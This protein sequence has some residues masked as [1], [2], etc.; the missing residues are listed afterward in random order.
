MI[1]CFKQ[2]L[3]LAV[4]TS[5]FVAGLFAGQAQAQDAATPSAKDRVA[6]RY[7]ANAKSGSANGSQAGSPAPAGDGIEA[8]IEKIPLPDFVKD[9]QTDPAV[10]QHTTTGAGLPAAEGNPIDMQ[11]SAQRGLDAN[12]QMQSARAILSG[13]EQQRRQAMANFGAVGTV[14]YTFQRTDAQVISQNAV[15]I[16]SNQIINSMT[17]SSL[18]TSTYS[19]SRIGYWKNLYQLQLTATQ[20]LFTGFKL[21]SSYQKAELSREQAE[22]NIKYTELSLIKAVQ[23]AF[24]TLLQARSNVQSNKDSVARLESQYKVA[25]AYYDVGLKPRLDV[26]QA[27]SDLAQAEQNLLKAENDV[28]VQTAQLNSLLNL[29]LNQQTNYVGELTYIPFPMSIEECLDTA[30]KLRPDLYMGV[31]TVQMAERD[32]KIAASTFYPQV[33]AQ[34]TYTK[35]GNQ[36]D[37]GLKDSSGATT[38]DSAAIG[39]GATLQAWDWGSTYFGVQSARENV[40]K[41][42]ADLA[43]LRLDV[44]YQVKTFYLNIQDAAKRISV[45]RTALEASREGYRMAVAR[46]QAQVGTS[47]DVLDAQAR[48]SSAEFNLTQALTDYQSALADIY[49]AMGV[50]NLSLVSN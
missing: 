42:Q 43:K 5:L 46:Y 2:R 17:G 14:S 28:L 37:L 48:V 3:F 50:K 41:V 35:Q 44:G 39:I 36:P 34:A 10:A 4:I 23:Q 20:P 33:Q 11:Q 21:L 31:K 49:V 16:P 27:E 19:S 45:A 22:A 26:L 29:P 32:V 7:T 24:L 40:K 13:A 18:A 12:P 38:P 30:Y 6:N 25:Q 8:K 1:A 15:T 9:R 47:T